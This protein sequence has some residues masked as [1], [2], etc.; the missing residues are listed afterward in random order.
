MPNSHSGV[1]F[2]NVVPSGENWITVDMGAN[3]QMTPQHVKDCESLIVE[4][5]L[6]MTQ[7]EVPESVVIETMRLGKQHKVKTLL[8]PAPARPTDPEL[9]TYVDILTPNA[10]EARIL[11]RLAPDDPTPSEE[12]AQQLLELGVQTVIVTQGRDGA[13]IVTEE[14]ITQIPSVAI[15]AIDVTGAGDSFNATLAVNLSLGKSVEDA[16]KEAVHSGAYTATHLG[17]IDGLPTSD[18]LE[19]FKQKYR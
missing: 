9:F 1:G 17:V 3:M 7:F 14:A 5:D 18:Q 10:I 2:V 4:S 19:A 15:D 8:N 16:V 11:L 13:M 6:I 12:L